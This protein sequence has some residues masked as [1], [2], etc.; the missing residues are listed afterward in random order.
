MTIRMLDPTYDDKGAPFE[1]APRVRSFKGLTVG[2]VSNGKKGTEPFFSAMEKIL[3]EEEGATSFQ[4]F[5]KDNYSAPVPAHILAEAKSW[6]LAF[7]GIG[8]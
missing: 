1:L 6:D 2:V 7:T 8:D 5:R 4:V 3:V